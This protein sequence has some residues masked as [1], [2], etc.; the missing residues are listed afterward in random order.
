MLPRPLGRE[1]TAVLFAHRSGAELCLQPELT[2]PVCRMYLGGGKFPAQLAYHGPRSA[3][4]P[5]NRIVEPGLADRV[6][7]AGVRSRSADI[8]SHA[9]GRGVRAAG[10]RFHD[11]I[12]D[13]AL[14]AGSSTHS[15]FRAMAWPPEAPFLAARLFPRAASR[16]SNGASVPGERYL[17]HLGTADEGD[18]RGAVG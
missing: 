2:I 17:A 1:I 15:T 14:F 9:G 3:F 5:T 13:L 7:C 8:E 11:Q 10:W 16:V 18:P 6:E 4:G 12:G